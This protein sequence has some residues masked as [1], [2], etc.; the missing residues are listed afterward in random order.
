M[1]PHA[2]E[3]HVSYAAALGLLTEGEESWKLALQL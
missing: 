2:R 3:R 1:T